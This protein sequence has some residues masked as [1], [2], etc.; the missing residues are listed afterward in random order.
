[1]LV[2]ETSSF[3]F[4][5]TGRS[6]EEESIPLISLLGPALL[7]D[8]DASELLRCEDGMKEWS[9]ARGECVRTSTALGGRKSAN[10]EMSRLEVSGEGERISTTLY[11][12]A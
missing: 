5:F 1:M 7:D 11:L 10:G 2:A 8:L 4:R 3:G 12:L 6:I 9:C